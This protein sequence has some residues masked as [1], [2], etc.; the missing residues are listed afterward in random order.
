MV[1]ISDPNIALRFLCF[2]LP[3][4]LSGISHRIGCSELCMPHTEMLHAAAKLVQQMS[5]ISDVT[6]KEKVLIRYLNVE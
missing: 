5:E 1:V 2:F 6:E 4:N 3:H